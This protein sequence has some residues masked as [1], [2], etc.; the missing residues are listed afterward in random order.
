MDNTKYYVLYDGE[1]GFCNHWVHWILKHDHKNQF[2][3][4]SLQSDFAQKF[5]KERGLPTNDFDSIILWKPTSFYLKKSE[6]IIAIAKLLG[7]KY[8]FLTYL[9]IFPTSIADQVYQ[10]VAKRRKKLSHQN[11]ELPS[12]EDRKKFIS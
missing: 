11:C 1:C 7:G 2:L 6:A 4:A 12:L 10:F 9:N 5:L 3:F 8:K